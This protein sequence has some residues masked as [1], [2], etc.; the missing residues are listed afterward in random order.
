MHPRFTHAILILLILALTVSV[1]VP[2]VPAAGNT[3]MVP[4][5]APAT[6][7]PAPVK[8]VT[9]IAPCQ[10]LAYAGAVSMWGESGFSQCAELPCQVSQS[11]YGAPVELHCYKQKAVTTGTTQVAFPAITTPVNQL[12]GPGPTTSRTPFPVPQ[13]TTLAVIARQATTPAQ[14]SDIPPPASRI[15]GN[16]SF[17]QPVI[18]IGNYLYRPRLGLDSPY[19]YLDTTDPKYLI[20]TFL[21]TDRIDNDQRESH[22]EV[23]VTRDWTDYTHLNLSPD[24]NVVTHMANFRY[25]SSAKNVR[26]FLWQVSRFP[27]PNDPEHWQAKYIPGLVA[28]GPV[29]PLTNSLDPG[30]NE[31][32]YFRINFAKVASRNPGD[33]PYFS[34][35]AHLDPAGTGG[36]VVV[37]DISRLPLNLGGIAVRKVN[38]GAVSLDLPMVYTSISPGEYTESEMAH[39]NEG[40]ILT[41]EDCAGLRS[42]TSLETLMTEEDQKFYVRLVPI[43]HDGTAGIPSIPVEVTVHRLQP[44]PVIKGDVTVKPPSARI[45]WYMRPGVGAQSGDRT[46]WVTIGDAA[47]WNA[48]AGSSSGSGD[49]VSYFTSSMTGGFDYYGSGF[50]YVVPPAAPVEKSWWDKMVGTFKDIFH[51]IAF[52]VNQYSQLWN[53][54]KDKVVEVAA[55]VLSYSTTLGYVKCEDIDGCDTV[56]HTALDIAMTAVGLPP[57]LPTSSELTDMGTEYLV[58]L[59]ADQLGA[60]EAY[61]T[62][63]DLYEDIP[64]YAKQPMKD[65][66]ESGAQQLVN[67]ETEQ[68][69]SMVFNSQNCEMPQYYYNASD[70]SHGAHNCVNATP[71]P[72]FVSYHPATVMVRVENPNTIATDRVVLAVSDSWNLYTRETRIIPSLRPGEGISVPVVLYENYWQFRKENGG[73][74]VWDGITHTDTYSSSVWTNEEFCEHA[75]WDEKFY[76]QGEDSFK[77]TFSLRNASGNAAFE[78]LD[79]TSSGKWAGTFIISDDNCLTSSSVRYPP[80]W[81]IFTTGYSINPQAEDYLFE[82]NGVIS[83][84]RGYMRKK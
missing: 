48:S 46:R 21:E 53:M 58:K 76:Q 6:L 40:L 35:T 63:K 42:P 50:H 38:I 26:M 27:F 83:L 78:N 47:F 44:C 65:A 75:K 45:V 10:C 29:E 82:E 68:R 84:T 11:I 81:Q 43:Y 70:L 28:L 39:P 23:Q 54:M 52:V 51:Y 57:T 69:H 17:R 16:V 72:I 67:G 9:C 49:G 30:N 20:S 19:I 37:A 77:V 24:K 62:A 36:R 64:D 56:L 61:D 60:G 13:T 25:T 22:T 41:C 12:A 14:F 1:I 4:T 71:D 18:T 66:A 3:R 7:T 5:F 34:G 31:F 74:C 59:G 15:A 79:E 80:G 32:R 8:T 2:A 33:P 55:V 73:P